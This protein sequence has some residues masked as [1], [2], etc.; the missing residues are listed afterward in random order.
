M[1]IIIIS[2]NVTV[3]ILNYFYILLGEMILQMLSSGILFCYK[4]LDSNL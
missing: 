2:I 3:S 1:H 4:M